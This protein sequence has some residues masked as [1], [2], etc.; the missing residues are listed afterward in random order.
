MFASAR[1]C[2]RRNARDLAAARCGNAG[3]RAAAQ[4]VPAG[5]GPGARRARG[6][7]KRRSHPDRRAD[8]RGGVASRAP[9]GR[10]PAGQPGR[11]RARE[12]AHGVSRALG[13]RVPVLRRELRRSRRSH[14]HAQPP[15]PPHRGRLGAVRPGHDPRPPN[16]L[17]LP[18]LRR[19]PT[20]RR[21]ALQ[22]RRLH[23]RLGSRATVA[24]DPQRQGGFCAGLD[25][26]YNVASDLALVGTINPDF[27]QVEADQRV[28]NLSTFET[29]FPE[30]RPFF[31]EGLDL[32]K[33]PL[34]V[35][36][37]GTYGGDAYQ[38]FYSRRIGRGTP[39]HDDLD[40]SDEQKIVY[41]QP[42]VPVLAAI[43]MSG[44]VG[45]ASVGLLTA[46]EPQVTAQV[47]E[48]D[49]HVADLRS[50]ESRST[51]VGR[52]RQ[53][54]GDRGLLGFT[55]TSVNP[56]LASP[57][58]GLNHRHAHAGG[59]D[60]TFYSADRSWDATVQALGSIL[61]GNIPEVLRD[62]T[63]RGE[64]SSGYATSGRLHHSAEYWASAIN[65]HLL[66]PR[67]TVNDLGFMPRA[68]MFR[69]IGYLAVRDPHPS[70]YWQSAQLLLGGR[71][72]H[73][74]R[75]TNRLNRDV[76]FE[77]WLNTKSFWFVDTGFDYFAPYVD[78]RELEDGTP[79]ERQKQL[80]WYGN[81]STDSRKPIQ[82]QF[83]WT[84]GR[85][86]PRF[87]RLNQL[88]GTLVLRPLPQLDG[89]VDFT[90]TES[91]GEIRQ[92]ATPKLLPGE[93]EPTHR[94]RSYILAPQ[95]ARSVSTTLRATY[96]FTPYLTLQAYGQL[97]TATVTY[98]RQLRADVGPGRSTVKLDA[99]V[100]LADEI[101]L[102]AD[103][104]QVGL[105]L[106]IILRWE[107]RTGSTLYLV[108]AHQ[109]AND[110]VPLRHGLDF[111]GELGLLS[112]AGVSHG[113]TILLK[114]DLL[115]AL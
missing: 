95:Q 63:F 31:L 9:P 74:Y 14:R 94:E 65:W 103:D 88:G 29:F 44:T 20:A 105:N 72:V 67:F 22:R 4:G 53:P 7:A 66:S 64:T 37:N 89:S 41:Q 114:V 52:V 107:W 110:V 58:L 10:L 109:S 68:N 75:F 3:T 33:T 39:T 79:L 34:R 108:Y 2:E 92:I 57:S 36:I 69:G 90:Y 106:N 71:E 50:V 98:G 82:V 6:E 100:P 96:S 86:F 73:D 80:Q 45:T 26:R 49:G 35:D 60:L 85:S 104:R 18:G 43:K 32:F 102:D 12:R 42:S 93:L 84:E 113:D 28:L 61:T 76:F 46:V 27:G 62:G 11:G 91:A 83:Y 8:G 81:L 59:P 23:H 56:I 51:S 77:G 19:G 5:N 21:A 24:F 13:R 17:P 97:F 112:A 38:I 78:D 87:Q 47:L 99:L 55:A 115:S 54:L 1:R 70:A 16:R 15:R 111:A 25:F 40:L 30:K 101:V 48:P